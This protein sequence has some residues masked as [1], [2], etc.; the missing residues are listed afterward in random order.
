[1]L[2]FPGEGVVLSPQPYPLSCKIYDLP[3]AKTVILLS[4]PPRGDGSVRVRHPPNPHLWGRKRF[5][6]LSRR[7]N[8]RNRKR[9]GFFP[10]HDANRPHQAAKPIAFAL[11]ERLSSPTRGEEKPQ[12]STSTANGMAGCA[13][14]LRQAREPA[15]AARASAAS[16]SRRRRGWRRDSRRTCPLPRPCRPG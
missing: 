1:M 8:I 12:P 10:Q 15:L 16:K 2:D 3:S 4:P 6:W 9:G 14:G 13:P 5:R 11:G 7:L